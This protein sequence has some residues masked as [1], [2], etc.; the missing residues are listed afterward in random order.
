LTSSC[1][2]NT[3]AATPRPCTPSGTPPSVSSR[4]SDVT[5]RG[6]AGC[7]FTMSRGAGLQRPLDE[8]DA[9]SLFGFK[10]LPHQA[11]IQAGSSGS[12][13][14]ACQSILLRNTDSSDDR[15]DVEIKATAMASR[16]LTMSSPTRRWGGSRAQRLCSRSVDRSAGDQ[17]RCRYDPRNFL[18]ALT[19]RTEAPLGG[20]NGRA[21]VVEP[22]RQADGSAGA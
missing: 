12:V 4:V 14:I 9:R 6:G 16:T 3:V 13:S 11:R 2:K 5:D 19:R 15:P 21:G 18:T 22:A 7:R 8:G 10:R 20:H 1:G 17:G